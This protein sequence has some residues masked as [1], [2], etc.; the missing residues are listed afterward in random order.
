MC[1]TQGKALFIEATYGPF[2]VFGRH[3]CEEVSVGVYAK[4]RDQFGHRVNGEATAGDQIDIPSRGRMGERIGTALRL[5]LT[6]D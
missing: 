1:Q 6:S 2:Y 4:M 5:A 3:A